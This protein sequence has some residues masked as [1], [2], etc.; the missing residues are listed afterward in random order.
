MDSIWRIKKRVLEELLEA[1]ENSLPNEF[2]CLLGTIK[3]RKFVEEFIVP[4]IEASVYST[5]IHLQEIPFDDS[6]VGSFHSHPSGVPEPSS[7]DKKLFTR[8][9]LNIIV[10]RSKEGWRVKAFNKNSEKI[11]FQLID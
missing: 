6:I 1:S 8:Y 10:G 5:S 3:D 11:E 2:A 9:K 7:A 4:R